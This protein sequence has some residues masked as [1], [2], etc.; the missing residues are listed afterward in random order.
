MVTD[1]AGW[2]SGFLL[3]HPLNKSYVWCGRVRSFLPFLIKVE[4]VQNFPEVLDSFFSSVF[5]LLLVFP[6]LFLQT[7]L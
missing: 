7:S 1:T 2:D 5:R 6:F 3:V 4:R